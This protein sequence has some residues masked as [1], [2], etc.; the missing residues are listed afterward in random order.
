M[1]D[2]LILRKIKLRNFLSHRETE[3]Q[4]MHGVNVFVGPNGAGKSSILEA[5][6]FALTGE[7]WRTRRTGDLVNWRASSGEVELEFSIGGDVYVLRRSISGPGTV[8]LKNGKPVARDKEGVDRALR[9]LL[10]L[11]PKQIENIV[12]VMQGGVTEL[13]RDLEPSKRREAIDTILGISD[14]REVFNKLK[15]T[16]V[17]V[18]TEHFTLSLY[19][20]VEGRGSLQ[21]ILESTRE[22]ITDR[23]NNLVS[24]MQR[25]E[26]EIIKLKKELQ[27][28]QRILQEEN[29]EKLKDELLQLERKLG[30]ISGNI[31]Y[32]RE[33]LRKVED[34]IN[35][36]EKEKS[37]LSNKLE[38]K[39]KELKELAEA[40][41][42][43]EAKG[44]I[45]ELEEKR[46]RLDT[47]E[48][49]LS[50][51]QDPVELL[52]KTRREISDIMQQYGE[53]P[54]KLL[55][56]KEGEL[57]ELEDREKELMSKLTGIETRLDEMRQRIESEISDID[58][59][60]K[61]LNS[62]S[63]PSCPLC[64]QQLTSEQREHVLQ[65]FENRKRE[66][67]AQLEEQEKKILSD[68]AKLEVELRGIKSNLERTTSVV[69]ELKQVVGQ[70]K[71]LKEQYDEEKYSKLLDEL[72]KLRK[73]KS[74]L[75]KRIGELNNTIREK[76]NLA[77]I[78]IGKLKNMLNEAEEKKHKGSIVENE[79]KYLMKELEEQSK[80]LEKR[81]E[82]LK[83]LLGQIKELE[84][85]KEKVER[86]K[87]E[88]KEKIKNLEEVQNR[89]NELENELSN[90]RE[91]LN[92]KNE[93]LNKLKMEVEEIN[94]AIYKV[95][96]I[97]WIR[98]NIFSDNAVPRM[99]R[100]RYTRLL[101]MFMEE[102]L[103]RFNIE[104]REASVDEDYNIILK[105]VNYDAEV[106]LSSISGGEQIAVCLAALL[107]LF[108]IVAGGRI[109]FI[110]LDEPTV[111][112]DD[113]RRRELVELLKEFQGGSIIPQLIVI[114]HDEEVREAA[115]R[116]FVVRK[117][118]GYSRVEEASMGGS[119]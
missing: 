40:T 46:N 21:A 74:L 5:I 112:L 61:M 25:L 94:K 78:D 92:K 71:I 18:N 15:D 98:E 63:E 73:E 104:Y 31:N 72:E 103:G 33:R 107:S 52:E 66:L 116:V 106:S 9:D 57:K 10:H 89:V 95:H 96:M 49:S 115:D 43:L 77:E 35:K 60:I 37:N 41:R 47:L 22:K 50:S 85:E 64:G 8:L 105:S 56:K 36:L 110:A 101:S 86:K 75:E 17:S 7:A 117:I 111:H 76:L 118:D 29:L 68:K 16:P 84:D 70:L 3:I 2:Q 13:F 109:G 113:D 6:Y 28:K 54:V 87:K 59:K 51:I 39:E 1:V 38:G 65:K 24:E 99:L 83:E 30:E 67:K 4:P 90:R 88:L 79:I 19:P 20:H 82:E 69:N 42:V 119:G 62:T 32:H 53:D 58:E 44:L 102:L 45:E 26:Q 97:K 91:D 48:K 114:T 23:Y 34:E 11:N 12:L 80:L 100:T 55:N 81:K 93:E 108:K 27:E 14:Y